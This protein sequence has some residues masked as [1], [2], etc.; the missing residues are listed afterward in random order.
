MSEGMFPA[1]VLDDAIRSAV[2]LHAHTPAMARGRPRW[3]EIAMQVA[4]SH[5]VTLDD[6]RSP[7]R[8]KAIATARH[9]AIGRIAAE[10]KLGHGEIAIRFNRCRHTALHSIRMWSIASGANIRGWTPDSARAYIAAKRW[11]RA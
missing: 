7:S 10:T 5:G 8:V 2:A 1:D 11:G 9:E 3:K 4:A 6:L